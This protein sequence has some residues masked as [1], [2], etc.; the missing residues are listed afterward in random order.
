MTEQ[1]PEQALADRIEAETAAIRERL[2]G[3]VVTLDIDTLTLG[4]LESIERASGRSSAEL[5]AAGPGSRRLVAVFVF[6]SRSSE[7][8]PSWRALQNLRPSDVR[9]SPA[10]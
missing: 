6:L 7:R 1:T 5:L 8:A 10:P 3:E 2:L 9:S 4:E